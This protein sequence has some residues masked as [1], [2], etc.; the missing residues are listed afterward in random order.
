MTEPEADD[1]DLLEQQR[2]PALQVG[3]SERANWPGEANPADAA[4]Q[5]YDAVEPDDLDDDH[6]HDLA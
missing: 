4:E 3:D 1:A 2:T 6:P 5:S